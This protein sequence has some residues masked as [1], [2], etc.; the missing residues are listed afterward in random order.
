M[1][2]ARRGCQ[3]EERAR[4]VERLPCLPAARNVPRSRPVR[5]RPHCSLSVTRFDF[6][7]PVLPAGRPDGSAWLLLRGPIAG[8][9]CIWC[10]RLE[11]DESGDISDSKNPFVDRLEFIDTFLSP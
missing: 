10:A 6:R 3:H 1:G 2:A 8:G 5:R 7:F 9:R 11:V 4:A